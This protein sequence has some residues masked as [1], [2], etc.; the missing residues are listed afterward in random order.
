M[1]FDPLSPPTFL[2]AAETRAGDS[3][4]R[5]TPAIDAPLN[6]PSLTLLESQLAG[7]LRGFLLAGSKTRE[8]EA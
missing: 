6:M 4:N 7:G 3:E 2:A 1:N 8:T 5:S